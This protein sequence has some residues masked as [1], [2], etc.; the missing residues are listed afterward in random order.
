[1]VRNDLISCSFPNRSLIT[2]IGLGINLRGKAVRFI[3]V[4]SV[5]RGRGLSRA[6][7]SF[8]S[9]AMGDVSRSR[10]TTID[11][12]RSEAVLYARKEIIADVSMRVTVQ[13]DG[14]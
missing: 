3:L 5:L 13:S 9:G 2:L 10:S 8:L 14:P 4:R 1:M 12:L 7:E 11:F 6:R